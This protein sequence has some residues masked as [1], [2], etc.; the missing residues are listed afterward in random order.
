MYN[1][2][3]M[4]FEWDEKKNRL[5]SKNHG[6]ELSDGKYVFADADRYDYVDDRQDYG[7]ERRIVVGKVRENI[8]TVVYTRRNEACRLLSVRFASRKKRRE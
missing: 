5:N 4:L 7:E 6:F 3:G 1:S 2:Y 8:L